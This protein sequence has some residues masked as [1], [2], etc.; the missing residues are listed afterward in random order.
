MKTSALVDSGSMVTTVSEDFLRSLHPQPTINGLDDLILKCPDSKSLPYLGYIEATIEAEFL[1]DKEV[2]VPALV[3]PSTSYHTE[4]PIVVGTNVIR[5]YKEMCSDT[6]DE[7]PSEWSNAFL[8]VQNGF[9]GSVR[10]TNKTSINLQPMEVVTVSGFVRKQKEVE[11]AVTEQIENASSKIGVCP[12]VVAVNK[13]GRN[14]RV[15]VK[16]FNM[17]ATVITI[18]PRSLLCQLQEVK[19]LRSCNPLED[20]TNTAITNQQTAADEHSDS[21]KRQK[22]SSSPILEL[23]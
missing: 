6:E 1:C 2:C 16:I 14:A 9:V 10:S 17:S 8:S 18:P 23:I 4:V 19:V 5:L 22:L 20:D 7:V 15:P 13:P 12:R 21:T 11:S 3:V